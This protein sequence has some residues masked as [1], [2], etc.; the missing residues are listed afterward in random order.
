MGKRERKND[1][2]KQIILSI[3]LS[4]VMIFSVFGVMIGSF[5]NNEMSYKGHRFEIKGNKYVTKINGNEMEF[6]YLPQITESINLSNDTA[7]KIKSAYVLMITFDPSQESNL[8]VME[9]VR[10]DLSQKLGKIVLSGVMSN[11]EQYQNFS[12][13]TCENATQ[14]SPVIVLNMSDNTSI[15]DAGNCIY[16]NARGSE[17][18]RLRD[19]ILYSYYGV[20]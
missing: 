13:I 4:A 2:R 9:L 19:R 16:L 3:V 15:I 1:K 20:I 14:Q 6:D 18:L 5:T 11:S 7:T 12:I 17:F 8:P 10:F